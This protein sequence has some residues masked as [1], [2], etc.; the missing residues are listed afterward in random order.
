MRWIL[1]TLHASVL[2]TFFRSHLILA[3]FAFSSWNI[4]NNISILSL[5]LFCLLLHFN[6]LI[7][8]F[9]CISLTLFLG[10]GNGWIWRFSNVIS[11]KHEIYFMLRCRVG[12]SVL[13]FDLFLRNTSS[14]NQFFHNNIFFFNDEIFYSIWE[15][16]QQEKYPFIPS[17]SHSFFNMVNF[18]DD[19]RC[20]III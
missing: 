18:I 2:F 4:G 11:I 6:D 20:H 15:Y 13:S 17:F 14:S 1:S 12:A 10:I 19:G 3:F 16:F 9:L 8:L 7:L 5:F